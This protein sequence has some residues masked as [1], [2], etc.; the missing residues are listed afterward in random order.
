[1]S[2]HSTSSQFALRRDEGSSKVM[3]LA[4]A[5]SKFVKP[6]STL[7]VAYSDARPNA[8]LMEVARQF[9]GTKPDFTLV[10]SGLVSVQ[11]ALLELNLVGTL[12]TSFAG[13]NYPMARPNR[14]FQRAVSEGRVRVENWSLWTLIARL[15]AG[16]LG[17]SHFPVG[18]LRDSSMA[19]DLWGSAYTE[20]DDPFG[21]QGT[22][23]AVAPLRPDIVLLQ[24]VAADAAGNIIM[25][26]PYGESMWGSLASK[27]GVIA[28]VERI[29]S[30]EEVRSNNVL[31]RIPAHKVVAVCEVPFGSHPY[32]LYNPGIRGVDAYVPDGPFMAD[33]LLASNADTTF[34]SWIA[35]WIIGC[36]SHAEYLER[37][38][39]PRLEAL[40]RG[41]DKDAWVAEVNSLEVDEE[42]TWNENELM[43]VVASRIIQERVNSEGFE[44]VLAGV[45]LANLSAWSAVRHVKAE[46]NNVELMAE[47]GM[48]G[49]DPRPGDPFIFANRNLQTAKWLSDVT[50]VLGAL[51]S[52][53]GTHALG[54]IGA[55]QIDSDF[56]TNSTLSED[57]VFLVG[58]GGANDIMSNAEEVLITIN[59]DKSRLVNV[60]PY[61]TCPG[62]RVKTVVT[63]GAVFERQDGNLVLTRYLPG[64]GD[65]AESAV[66]WI[67]ER[68]MWDFSVSHDI[69]REDDPTVKELSELRLFDPD[70]TFLREPKI[71]TVPS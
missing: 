50:V 53:P 51:V 13:E 26:A 24:G 19:R 71:A 41:A 35:D 17:L 8:A 45:G 20:L 11:H 5:V 54:V 34:Q 36:T 28:C 43:V 38:G 44:V 48:F 6:E 52:G 9:A 15:M 49:Y 25:A 31:V 47:I 40:S 10:T 59:L 3:D 67:R 46:G 55:A 66:A 33:V 69:K 61:I 16:A 64:S 22:T 58:S 7:H 1:M 56:N 63:S 62:D 29:I 21:K 37:L 70:R 60:L 23:G 57:G 32:G 68:C 27:T 39:S 30:T 14:A 18:S 65:D 2:P 42:P 12:L 4:D